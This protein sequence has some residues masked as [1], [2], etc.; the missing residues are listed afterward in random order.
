[1]TAILS[2]QNLEKSFGSFVAAHDIS[3]DIARGEIVGIIGAN[4]AGK[5]T[6][7]NMISGHVVPSNGRIVFD[8]HDITGTASRNI[9]KLGVGRSF[10]I[11]QVFARFTALENMCVAIA[12]A[13]CGDTV[14]AL[15]RHRLMAPD[16]VRDADDSLAQFG[17]AR[18]RDVPANTLSQG[19]R[20]ILDVAMAAARDP[21]LIMLDEPTSGVSREERHG[22]MN[23]VMTALKARGV[24]ILF[25]EHDMEVVASHAGRVLAFID[26]TLVADGAPDMVF[27]RE[28]VRARITGQVAGHVASAN[29]AAAAAGAAHA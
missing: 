23:S 27:A 7:V 14:R 18:Y 19:V 4:G 12:V 3:C 24:T 21:K 17:I 25:V 22:L 1:M 28:D 5:T 9:T 15:V 6:F 20:K 26:G 13:R 16:I 2:A 8:G 11:A 29:S 10:Q